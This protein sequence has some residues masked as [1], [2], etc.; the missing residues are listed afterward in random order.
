MAWHM[1]VS[2]RWNTYI[3]TWGYIWGIHRYEQLSFVFRLRWCI[4][5]DLLPSSLFSPIWY[6]FIIFV[7]RLCEYNK[8]FYRCRISNTSLTSSPSSRKMSQVWPRCSCPVL[9]T[10]APYVGHASSLGTCA[11][12]WTRWVRLRLSQEL[13]DIW[14]FSYFFEALALW[15]RCDVVCLWN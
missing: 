6:Y 1:N 10:C 9:S 14:K 13:K 5:T 2:K 4:L 12:K 15:N 8:S 11:A 3:Y 7:F